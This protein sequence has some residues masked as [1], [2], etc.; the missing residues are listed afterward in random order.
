MLL[1]LG[2]G[3]ALELFTSEASSE[4]GLWAQE[5]DYYRRKVLSEL[6]FQPEKPE[7]QVPSRRIDAQL[8]QVG[9]PPIPL[10]R[11]ACSR[12]QQSA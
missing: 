5:L 9:P 6:G 12:V 11:T 3:S 7:A 8:A 10:D 4:L 2:A 1:S